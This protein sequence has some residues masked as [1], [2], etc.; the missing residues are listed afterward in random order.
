[1]AIPDFAYPEHRVAIE[2]DGYRWHT[3]RRKWQHDLARRNALVALGWLVI[4]VT[5]ED[6]N[7]ASNRV[8]EVI[9]ATLLDRTGPG[10]VPYPLTS[11]VP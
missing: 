1:M 2:T 9:S 7:S 11:G 10:L 5:D 6:L 8:V 4:H 3:G